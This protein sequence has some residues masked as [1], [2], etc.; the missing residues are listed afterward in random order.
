MP[1]VSFSCLII[2]GIEVVLAGSL[3]LFL[4]VTVLVSIVWSRHICFILQVLFG[5]FSAGSAP[6]AGLTTTLGLLRD[7]WVCEPYLVEQAEHTSIRPVSPS[8]PHLGHHSSC[9]GGWSEFKWEDRRQV[10]LE[11]AA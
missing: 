1:F 6:A 7:S 8:S 3:V 2:L 10:W 5:S 4:K 9:H 11:E